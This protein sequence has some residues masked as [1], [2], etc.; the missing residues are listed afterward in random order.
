MKNG[1]GDPGGVRLDTTPEQHGS[2]TSEGLFVGNSDDLS[3]QGRTLQEEWPRTYAELS[4]TWWANTRPDRTAADGH[5]DCGYALWL[6]RR[7]ELHANQ[8]H[9]AHAYS[10]GEL[11]AAA[12]YESRY[13]W[14]RGTAFRRPIAG[15]GVCWFNLVHERPE[16]LVAARRGN[17]SV[18]RADRAVVARRAGPAAVQV[19]RDVAVM[20]GMPAK[21]APLCVAERLRRLTAGGVGR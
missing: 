14:Q 19:E 18:G 7:F 4:A 17:P 11:D 12:A 21:R 20:W 6:L 3:A 15:L 9:A 2:T 10:R 5:N 13:H 8:L 16:R 1:V